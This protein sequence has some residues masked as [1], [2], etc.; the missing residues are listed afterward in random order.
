MA[1]LQEDSGAAVA[2][3]KSRIRV[4]T[5][6]VGLFPAV[7]H[8]TEQDGLGG[9]CCEQVSN[10]SEG[11]LASLS[12]EDSEAEA[13]KM[14]RQETPPSR[15][16]LDDLIKR[17]LVDLRAKSRRVDREASGAKGWTG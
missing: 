2:A 17:S 5:S 13:E 3:P 16:A 9:E 4:K 7:R 14:L 8:V 1:D 15:E 11:L 12:V 6:P 10:K